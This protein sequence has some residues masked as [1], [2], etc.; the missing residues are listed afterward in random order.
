MAQNENYLFINK[1]SKNEKGLWEASNAQLVDLLCDFHFYLKDEYFVFEAEKI[2]N[3]LIKKIDKFHMLP[4]TEKSDKAHCDQQVDFAV[5]L[6][7]LYKLTKNEKY[8]NNSI[9]IMSS[10]KKYFYKK[11]GIVEYVNIYDKTESTELCKIK[12][13]I[14]SLKGWLAIKYH[15][16]IYKNKEFTR[17][18]NDR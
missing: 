2:A 16:E 13:L 4:S 1:W 14:L 9:I 15:D 6:I 18:L 7:K 10:I 5:A 12:F 8:L 17:L 11:Y 3:E